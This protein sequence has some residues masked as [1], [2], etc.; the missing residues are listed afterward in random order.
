TIAVIAVGMGLFIEIRPGLEGSFSVAEVDLVANQGKPVR[1][2]I[3]SAAPHDSATVTVELANNL[4]LAGFPQDHRLE[5]TTALAAGRN[6]LTLPLTLTDASDSQFRVGLSYESGRQNIKV[7]V[8]SQPT[9]SK[10]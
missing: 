3:D 6:L 10:A 8:K 4:E 5:R 9:G 7:T 2:V 1:L